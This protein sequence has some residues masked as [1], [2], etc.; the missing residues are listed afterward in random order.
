MTKLEHERRAHM[1]RALASNGI[2]DTDADAL[3]RI[4]M[5]SVLIGAYQTANL[6]RCVAFIRSWNAI[7]I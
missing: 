7:Q 4:S 3:R 1:D 6:A 2:T 5:T